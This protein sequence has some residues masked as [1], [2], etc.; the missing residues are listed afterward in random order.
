MVLISPMAT[1]SCDKEANEL[2][3]T[4]LLM[5]IVFNRDKHGALIDFFIVV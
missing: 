5:D 2:H 1:T 4:F 3:D